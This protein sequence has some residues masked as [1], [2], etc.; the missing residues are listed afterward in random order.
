MKDKWCFKVLLIITL[1]LSHSM[2]AV[3]TYN[4]CK[5]QYGSKYEGWS[6]SPVISFVLAIPYLIGILVCVILLVYFKWDK[7]N[8]HKSI[9]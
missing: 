9:E 4:Y 5:F 7:E 1:I 8:K 3:V 2:C 6:V